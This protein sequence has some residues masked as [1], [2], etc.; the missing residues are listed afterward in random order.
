M[1]ASA[2]RSRC[3]IADA[4]DCGKPRRSGT[5]RRRESGPPRPSFAPR[6][7]EAHGLLTAALS[8]ART[9]E[10]QVLPR[11][12]L[13]RESTEARYAAG[14]LNLGEVLS[15]RRVMPACG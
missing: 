3:S 15:V 1:W 14:D 10:T 4:V 13:V 11:M 5:P 9:L 7:R 2:F 12:K 8:D 6:L